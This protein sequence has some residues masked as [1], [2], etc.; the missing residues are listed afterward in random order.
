M[1][2]FYELCQGKLLD[3]MK[4]K[5]YLPIN[6][7]AE[8]HRLV[9]K[10]T[11]CKR[12]F[13]QCTVLFAPCL[14]NTASKKLRMGVN[15]QKYSSRW[16]FTCKESLKKKKKVLL[17]QLNAIGIFY[18]CHCRDLLV[19]TLFETSHNFNAEILGKCEPWL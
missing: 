1:Y 13:F 4:N 7:R 18:F 14:G 15:M 5:K 19:C 10:R 16:R 12:N 8:F 3:I 2:C 11:K 17:N 9:S 6:R